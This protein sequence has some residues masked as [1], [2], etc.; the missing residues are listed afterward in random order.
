MASSTITLSPGGHDV[1]SNL[2][3]LLNGYRRDVLSQAGRIRPD[4]KILVGFIER[5]LNRGVD[6]DR[7]YLVC[8]W[9]AVGTLSDVL[10]ELIT[11]NTLPQQVEQILQLASSLP[12]G[13]VNRG[14]LNAWLIDNLWKNLQHPPLAYLGD[15]FRYRTADGSNNVIMLT[16]EDWT[17]AY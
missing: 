6:N 13:S 11:T 16:L 12:N 4:L 15:G 1:L 8:V 10:H 14:R 17:R 2:A 9:T 7:K 3:A 5:V